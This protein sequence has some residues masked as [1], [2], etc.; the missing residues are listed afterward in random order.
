ML[1]IFLVVIV[2]LS[3]G[4]IIGCKECGQNFDTMDALR[5]HEKSEQQDKG[6]LKLQ[7]QR[8]FYKT[9]NKVQDEVCMQYW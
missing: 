7:M 2:H 4:E 5:E 6:T 8:N 1:D 9:G 3:S